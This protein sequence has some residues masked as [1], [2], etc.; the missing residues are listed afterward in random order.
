MPGNPIPADA[1]IPIGPN[2]NLIAYFPNYDLD[3]SDPDFY[4]LS[5][6]IDNI[7]LAKNGAGQFLTPDWGGFS[8]MP[9][10]TAGQ[11]YQVKSIAD[12]EIILNY[13]PEQEMV[14]FSESKREDVRNWSEPLSTG[15]NMSV[16]INAISGIKTDA[17]DQVAAYSTT[18]KLLGVGDV[19]DGRCGIAIWGDDVSTEMV[20]GASKGEAFELKF[21]DADQQVVQD[22]EVSLIY[23][24][25]PVYTADDFVALDVTVRSAVPENYYLSGNYPNPFNSVTRLTF[26]M[27]EAN[28]ININVYDVSGRLVQNLVNTTMEAGNHVITWNAENTSAGVYVIR[29]ESGSFSKAQKVMLVK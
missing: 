25:T 19:I 5:G 1:D 7:Q 9:P 2:W 24:G 3:A 8:N 29:M 16:L 4:V 20:D 6:I 15:A 26:G 18:G 27:P 12:E 11:G 23:T 17:G 10:W 28:N 22:L 14:A 21:W 13:P